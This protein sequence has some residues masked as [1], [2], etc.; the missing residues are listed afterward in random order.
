LKP[1]ALALPEGGELDFTR[2]R[3]MGVLNVTPDSFSDGGR[4]LDPEFAIAHGR[5]L[6]EEGADLI[7]VG[8][9][10]TRPGSL[11]VPP[12]V[13]CARILPVIE[14]LA[15]AGVVLSVDTT[16]ADVAARALERGAQMVNDISGFRFDPRMLDLI[17]ARGVPA[18]AMHTLDRPGVMQ[19]APA[20]DDVV[21]EVRDHLRERLKACV[22]RGVCRSQIVLDP[23]I[24]FG[25][26]VDHNL[27][28]L[29][30]LQA[31]VALGQPV[32]VG[33]SRKAF[34]GA[35]TG[36]DV[37]ERGFATGASVAAA[38]LAG[39]HLVRVHE[40]AAARDAVRVAEA[41]RDARTCTTD[42]PFLGWDS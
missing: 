10:S 40:V 17:A 28:L 15:A 36:R 20:Y 34:L 13:Q 21:A 42:R 35:L 2:V 18:V 32:L 9:E 3:V 31:L 16:S 12:E 25:K 14:A 29:A 22:A 1:A 37:G 19:K 39:A 4:F 24:G 27:G 41:I 5:R 11:P 7:D 23:G 30:G 8:G 26:T 6:H 33:T 38:V